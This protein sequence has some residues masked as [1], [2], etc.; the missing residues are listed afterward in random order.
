M[1]LVLLINILIVGAGYGLVAMGFA[2]MSSVSPFFNMTLGSI[3][4]FGAYGVYGLTNICS[5]S[6][7]AAIP[8]A[9]LFCAVMAVLLEKFIYTPL[10]SKGASPMVL[11]VASLG[12]YTI[13]EALIHLCFGPQYQILGGTLGQNINLGIFSMPKVQFITIVADFAVFGLVNF[14]LYHTFFGKTVRAVNANA[15]LADIIGLNN[16]KIILI[17]SALSGL[18]LG[19]SGVLTGFDTGL[20]PTMGFNLLFKGIIAAIIGGSGS[21]LGPFLGAFFLAAAENIGVMLWASEWRDLVAFIIFILF[22][23]FRPQGI[24]VKK[25]K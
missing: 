19:L 23:M 18:I 14:L 15:K 22:L 24:F 21:M 9:V 2:L 1:L 10:Q 25:E 4:A 8:T 5:L 11:L 6:P 3:I 17:V 7:I 12:I 16:N 13:F 20:E